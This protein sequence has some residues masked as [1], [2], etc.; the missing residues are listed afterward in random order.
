VSKSD[1]PGENGK[2]HHLRVE[3]KIEE[4][5]LKGVY[6]FNQVSFPKTGIVSFS[7][8]SSSGK[9]FG[10]K[11]LQ[12]LLSIKKQQLKMKKRS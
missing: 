8:H 6:G 4:E 5:N 1:A 9:Y 2:A 3:Q 12:E 7:L 10:Q 11:K